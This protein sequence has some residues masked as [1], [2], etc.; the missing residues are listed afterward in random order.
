MKS[1]CLVFVFAAA[2]WGQAI[3]ATVLGMVTDSS[4]AV[5]A[6]ALVSIVETQ[7]GVKRRIATNGEGLYTQPYLPPGIY[8]VDVEKQGFKK[9]SRQ[10]IQV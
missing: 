1:L 8:E 9:V 5:V 4:G 10:N 2:A 3:T 6:D 7:T